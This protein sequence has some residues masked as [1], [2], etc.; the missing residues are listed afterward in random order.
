MANNNV[1]KEQGKVRWD[2]GKLINGP[3]GFKK[4][5]VHFVFDVKLDG[6]HEKTSN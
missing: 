1:F 2:K 4:S 5:H 3:Q 6:R